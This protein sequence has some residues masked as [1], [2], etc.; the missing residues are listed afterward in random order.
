MGQHL[1]DTTGNCNLWR[2]PHRVYVTC[3][4]ICNN[5][6]PGNYSSWTQY[7]NVLSANIKSRLLV[8]KLVGTPYEGMANCL[9]YLFI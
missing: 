5:K 7:E 4:T 9:L 3:T 6:P 8:E 2:P 1:D